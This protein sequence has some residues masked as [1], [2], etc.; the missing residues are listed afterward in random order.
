MKRHVCSRHFSFS[1]CDPAHVRSWGQPGLLTYGLDP[2][3]LGLTPTFMSHPTRTF[4]WVSG[5][6]LWPLDVTACRVSRGPGPLKI[7]AAE[8]TGDVDDLADE[9]KPGDG[10]GFEGFRREFRRIDAA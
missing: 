5:V 8:V 6:R 4:E 7:E 3:R 10:P 2:K 9:I 1:K